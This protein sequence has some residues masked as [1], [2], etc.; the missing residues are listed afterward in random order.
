MIWGRRLFATLLGVS[1]I[2]LSSALGFSKF[3]LSSGLALPE[4]IS[5]PLSVVIRDSYIG[6]GTVVMITN[7]TDK[8][9]HECTLAVNDSGVRVFKDTLAPHA[10]AEIGWL[11]LGY[12]LRE[13]DTVAIDCKGYWFAYTTALKTLNKRL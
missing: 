4:G 5:P 9:L 7:V 13:S 11:E 8:Y 10:K 6:R 12:E 1:V 2:G 3:P